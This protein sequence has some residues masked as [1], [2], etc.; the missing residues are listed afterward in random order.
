MVGTSRV[1]RSDLLLAVLVVVL[2]LLEVSLNGAVRPRAAAVPTELVAALALLWKRR[3]PLATVCV[4]AGAAAAETAL[5]VPISQPIVPLVALV[6]SLWSL[7]AGESLARA[8]LGLG[9]V[10]LAIGVA[11]AGIVGSASIRV[12]NFLFGLVVAS[13]AFTAGRIVHARTADT[14]A[15][16]RR[17]AQLEAERLTVV[18]EERERIAREL[19]DVIAHSVSV[20]VVQASAASEVLKHDPARA[21]RPL[22]AVEATGRQALLEMG[23]L[24]GLLREDDLPGLEPQ[25][26]L[27]HLEALA[28]QMTEAGLPVDLRIDGSPR[29]LSPGV[30]LSVYR[31]AQEALTNALKH[32]GPARARVT[33]SF[34]GDA[35]V[36]EVLDDGVGA[37]E[38]LRASGHGLI[39]MRER[40]DL[41]GGTLEAGPHSQGGFAVRAYMPLRG[42]QEGE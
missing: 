12:G 4:V 37:A 27:E 15:L 14:S 19:H 42:D 23:R 13:G 40:V 21:A 6:I 34:D 16:E 17:T 22:A 2:A 11:T 25:P 1:R 26:G 35:L 28:N 29:A 20:M 38:P 8:I 41:F 30:E 5:G 24:V 18:A 39:G 3:F 9:V 31:I 36:V 32:A 10:T 33:L 7:A